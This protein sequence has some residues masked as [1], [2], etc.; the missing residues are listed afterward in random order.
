MCEYSEK[1][2][3]CLFLVNDIEEI[4]NAH[5]ASTFAPEM[6]VTFVSSVSNT[7]IVVDLQ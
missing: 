1:Y 5:D 4:T 7:Q 2:F 6:R 3:S